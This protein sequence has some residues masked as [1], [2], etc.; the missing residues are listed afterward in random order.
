MQTIIRT[1]DEDG[2]EVLSAPIPDKNTRIVWIENTCMVY[3][4]GDVLPEIV[5]E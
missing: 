3:E 5:D 1:F 2:A 4:D